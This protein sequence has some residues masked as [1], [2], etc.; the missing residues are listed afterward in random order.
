MARVVQRRLQ[1]VVEEELPESQCGFRRGHACT[2]M[3]FTVRQLTEKAIQ[4]R[5]KKFLVFLDLKKAYDSVPREGLWTTLEKLGIPEELIDIVRSFHDNMKAR[6][7]V[8]GEL[9]EETEVE[10]GL[11]Q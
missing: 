2:D 8:D 6:I 1:R 9:L 5:A 10:N 11:R 7:R 3:I 4:H